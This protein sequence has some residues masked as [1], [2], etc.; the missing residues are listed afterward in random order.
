[1]LQ[2][3]DQ[4]SHD[5][6][7]CRFE[8]FREGAKEIRDF[9]VSSRAISELKYDVVDLAWKEIQN[10]WVG[11]CGRSAPGVLRFATTA[12]VAVYESEPVKKQDKRRLAS[13][14]REAAGPARLDRRDGETASCLS[15]RDLRDPRYIRWPGTPLG[16]AVFTIAI[17]CG[18]TFS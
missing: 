4:D 16:Q 9:V 18:T 5:V 11:E 10:H 15:A 14:L 1:M 7:E 12:D 6:V 8:E 3:D 2:E 17:L 13:S